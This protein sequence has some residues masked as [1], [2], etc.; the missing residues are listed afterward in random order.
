[1]AT[2]NKRELVT[3]QQR[4]K[5]NR[6]FATDAPGPGGAN[7]RYDIEVSYSN[8]LLQGTEHVELTF[9][10]GPRNELGSTSG[11]IDTDL[12]EIVRDRLISFQEGEFACREN[13]LALTHIEDALLWLNKRVEDRANRGVLGKNKE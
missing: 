2:N 9:Q 7:H 6:V 11:I 12:L 13:A 8:E 4:N 5:L 10:K 1:M 3:I